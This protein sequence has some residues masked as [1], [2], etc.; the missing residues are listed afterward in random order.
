MDTIII[1]M[2]IIND[3]TAVCMSSVSSGH[4]QTRVLNT[5]AEADLLY[6]T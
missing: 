1:R 3:W 4:E 2:Q 6:C 5:V